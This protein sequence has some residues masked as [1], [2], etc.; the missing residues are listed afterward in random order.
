MLIEFSVS[1]FLSFRERV[2]LSLVK[3]KGKELEESNTISVDAPFTP[4]LLRGA[5]V[6]GANSAGKSNLIK[7][8]IAMQAIVLNSAKEGQS[9]EPLEVTPFLFDDD[10]SQNPTEFEIA[11]VVDA[12]RYQYGFTATQERIVEEW[13]YAYPKGRPQRW[14]ERIFDAK[15][16]KYVWGSMDKLTGKKQVWQDATR[17]NALFFSAAVQLNNQQLMPLY[18]WFSD[19]LRVVGIGSWDPGFTMSLCDQKGS[20]KKVK[21]FLK[22][23]DLNISDIE[24]QKKLFSSTDLPK[25]LSDTVR[26][27][28][29]KKLEGES[30]AR[31][32]TVHFTESGRKVLLDLDDE[33]DGTQ[34]IFALAGPWLDSL[35]H[36][37]TL[38]IDELH[39]NLHPMMVRFLVQLFSDPATNPNN[40]QLIFTT[41]DATLLDQSLF[42]RDQV[43][44]CEKDKA[45]AT[46]LYPLTDFNPRAK[47]ENLERGYLA[48]R[49]GALPYI[50]K[51]NVG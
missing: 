8:L 43:W 42:R 21:D 19:F 41:H 34:K 29:L 39:D 31:V 35:E 11:F 38:L 44:F 4:E 13:L 40:A 48:G 18:E 32:K 30:I 10:S 36:G 6:F 5:V 9:G 22:A 1:N 28:L 49:Y 17:P 37:Y 3:G 25:E 15:D 20:R 2:T 33:S 27:K 24:I 47:V 23:A 26:Q 46:T 12:I 7:A 51:S 45:Q 14:I 50:L 16:N